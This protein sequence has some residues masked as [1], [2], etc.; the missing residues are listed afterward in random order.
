MNNFS[1]F[2]SIIKNFMSAMGSNLRSIQLGRR[3][4]SS[5]AISKS[6]VSVKK[7][8]DLDSILLTRCELQIMK[9]VWD[10]GDVTVKDVCEVL[11]RHKAMAYTTVLTFMNILERKGALS[12]I[13][14]GRAFLYRP[15]LSQP[16]A[17]RNHVRD[18]IER[19]FDGRPEKLLADVLSNEVL[20]PEQMGYVKS[21]LGVWQE[22]EVAC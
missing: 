5:C 12:H 6:G 13:Q 15:I 14:S 21:Y 20:S 22:N 2:C 11:S 18:A 8:M 19:F 3:R 1:A 4:V 10:E 7:D 17:T 9:V 16:Q